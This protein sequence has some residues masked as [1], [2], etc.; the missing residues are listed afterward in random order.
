MF[1]RRYIFKWWIFPLSFFRFRGCNWDILPHPTSTKTALRQSNALEHSQGAS[2][3]RLALW[4]FL[5]AEIPGKGPSKNHLKNRRCP[6][7]PNMCIYIC[8]YTKC[9]FICIYLWSF[10]MRFQYCHYYH[11]QNSSEYYCLNHP[12]P[13]KNYMSPQMGPF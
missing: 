5:R 1:N 9:V 4:W 12:H 11:Y 3:L 2:H 13:Q 8:T 6:K 10:F 7:I